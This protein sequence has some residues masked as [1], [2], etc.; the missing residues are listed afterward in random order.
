MATNIVQSG[1]T[2]Q[3]V[4]SGTCVSG[5]P[6]KFGTALFGIPLT[7]AASGADVALMITGRA[8]IPKTGGGGITF[9][10]GDKVYWSGTLATAT[11]T[12]SLVG[13]C[14]KAATNA[15][16]TVEISLNG[17]IMTQADAD[18]L[19]AA[20]GGSATAIG[21]AKILGA[22]TVGVHRCKFDGTTAPGV[23]D[24]S[25]SGYHAGSMW[26]DTTGSRIYYAASVGVG[27]ASWVAIPLTSTAA[28]IATLFGGS[29]TAIGFAKIL[30]ATTVGIHRS[31]FDGTTAPG[32][33]DD[34]A[35][36]YHAGSLWFDTTA[37]RVYYAITVGVGTATWAAIPLTISGT[38]AVASGANNG[39]ASVSAAFNSKPVMLTL[40]SAAGAI[41]AAD[42]YFTGAIAAGTLT[43]TVRD[44]SGA[45]Q[46][47]SSNLVF[48]Y[49]ATIQ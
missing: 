35:S 5:T 9:A 38:V 10:V 46:N 45:A 41:A 48:A 18:A 23:T 30:G 26:F 16:T 29:A 8:N 13:T 39:T 11:A 47:A 42:A 2:I 21:F 44:L 7:D 17:S 6:I 27:A 1:L 40:Q 15:A 3:V 24:D 49:S 4:A 20:F 19:A 36:G 43:V 28:T 12:D 34:S 37:G 25:A 14:T 31:K 22:S 32:A 33:T